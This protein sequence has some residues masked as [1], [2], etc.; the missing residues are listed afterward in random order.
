MLKGEG[1]EKAPKIHPHRLSFGVFVASTVSLYLGNLGLGVWLIL[2]GVTGTTF[3]TNPYIALS[4]VF[5]WIGAWFLSYVAYRRS[6]TFGYVLL[7]LTVALTFLFF[8]VFFFVALFFAAL[9]A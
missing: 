7:G 1:P 2:T 6:H 5:D 8:V 3:S 9:P 4:S